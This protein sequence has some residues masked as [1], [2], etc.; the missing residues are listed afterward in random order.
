[1]AFT[2]S[3]GNSG[4]SGMMANWG[5]MMMVLAIFLYFTGMWRMVSDRWNSFF[6]SDLW[7]QTIGNVKGAW[8]KAPVNVPI[9][10]GSVPGVLAAPPAPF[11]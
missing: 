3:F 6:A 10:Q 9:M 5:L 7:T 2:V 4:G 1:M 8:A 11:R